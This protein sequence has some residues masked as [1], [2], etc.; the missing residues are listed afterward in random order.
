MPWKGIKD[1]YK[2]WLSE[3][4]LQQTRVEQGWNYYEKFVAAFPSVHHL[5]AAPEN[6]VFKMWEG[7]G[8]YTRCKNLITTAKIISTHYNGNFPET[9]EE[10]KT[11]KGIGPYT[12]SAIASFAFDVPVAVVD[13]NVQRILA[14]YFGISTPT[15][16]TD[17]KKM[18]QNLAQ[19]LMDE[20]QPGV[21]NQAIMDF[22]AIICKPNNPL[23]SQCVQ[24]KDCEAFKHDMVKALPV[25]QKSLLKKERWFYYFLIELEDAV[26]IRKRTEKDIWQNL[27]D[28]VLHESD[29]PIEDILQC[30]AVFKNIF[31]SNSFIVKNVS[32]AR[33]HQLTHQT[34]NGQLVTVSIKSPLCTLQNYVLVKKSQLEHYAFPQFI[35]AFLTRDQLQ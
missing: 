17:G 25:K 19:A 10:I 18:Y 35:N 22:G 6:A 21:Y 20:S 7:L 9:Y 31:G 1:P 8:Y 29:S 28:F 23:C 11:L 2:I 14:R 4:I 26:Y 33:K 32:A 12:A 13:G 3:I 5:A 34:I 15:D 30:S 16:T 24:Q 27:H